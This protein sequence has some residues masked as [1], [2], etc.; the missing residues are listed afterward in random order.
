[1]A[2]VTRAGYFGWEDSVKIAGTFS[3]G[4]SGVMAWTPSF[5]WIPGMCFKLYATDPTYGVLC[6]TNGEQI[7][8]IVLDKPT[9]LAQPPAAEKATV[10]HGHS[11]ILIDHT[12]EAAAGTVNSSYLAYEK[13][14]VEAS[15]PMNLLYTNSGGKLTTYHSGSAKRACGFVTQVPSVGNNYSLGLVLF[16]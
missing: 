11:R 3:S 12:E 14:S 6:D 16:G 13:I 15:S 2:K 1:M 7:F 5:T 10:L 9:E 8:G 4:S